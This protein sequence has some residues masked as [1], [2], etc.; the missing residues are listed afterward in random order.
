MIKNPQ[1]IINP[2]AIGAG[3]AIK[4]F[5][6]ECI[7]YSLIK[8]KNDLKKKIKNRLKKGLTN[9]VLCGGDG[10]LNMFINIYM[11]LPKKKREKI[12]LGVLPGGNANDF[13][14]VMRTPTNMGDAY[15][16]ILKGKT[17]KVDLVKAN[18]KYFITGGGIGLLTEIAEEVDS[19]IDELDKL[20]LQKTNIEEIDLITNTLNKLFKRRTKDHI[21]FASMMKKLIV[22]YK[23]IK[24]LKIDGVFESK[25]TFSGVAIQNQDFIGKRFQFAPEASNS[26]GYFEICTIKK[27][28]DPITDFVT[29]LKVRQGKH[30]EFNTVEKIRAKKAI[31][32]TSEEQPFLADGERLF[33]AKKFKIDIV[34]K[35]ITVFH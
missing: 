6:D 2:G 10:T 33:C 22:G 9:F 11:D 20:K 30:V 31:I 32:T 15:N 25:D 29:Y 17:K 26:D 35:A 18:K 4:F 19:W 34:P 23:G 28:K 24:S 21:Y 16:K 3:K 7:K 14:M 12:R 1:V 8:D 13:A 5:G 27:S